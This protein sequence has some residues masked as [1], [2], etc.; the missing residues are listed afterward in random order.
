MPLLIKKIS[1]EDDDQDDPAELAFVL[2]TVY[3]RSRPKMHRAIEPLL[4]TMGLITMIDIQTFY[5]Q[6][7]IGNW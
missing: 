5:E 1:A 4:G 7:E 3:D 2:V 6:L